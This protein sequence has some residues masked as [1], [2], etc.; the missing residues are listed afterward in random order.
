ME[1]AAAAAAAHLEVSLTDIVA[2][3]PPCTPQPV[4]MLPELRLEHR[5][6]ASRVECEARFEQHDDLEAEVEGI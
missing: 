3:C 4:R 1:L 5:L 6:Q 2:P